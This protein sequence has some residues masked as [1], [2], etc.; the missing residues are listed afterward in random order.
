MLAYFSARECLAAWI[1]VAFANQSERMKGLT[2]TMATLQDDL[3][4]AQ[5]EARRHEILGAA[6]VI[7]GRIAKLVRWQRHQAFTEMQIGAMRLAALQTLADG[8]SS[9]DAMAE[10]RK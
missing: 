2:A 3:K 4:A 9:R 5:E 1:C 10:R 7:A 8:V 6:T